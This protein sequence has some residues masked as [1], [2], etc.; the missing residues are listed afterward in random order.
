L[1]RKN[2]TAASKAKASAAAAAAPVVR[3]AG[4]DDQKIGTGSSPGEK[5]LKR[6]RIGGAGEVTGQGK[7]LNSQYVIRKKVLSSLSSFQQ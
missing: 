5:V 1:N 2:A 4:D 3:A 6:D 7:N